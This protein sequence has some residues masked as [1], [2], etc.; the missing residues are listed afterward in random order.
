[1]NTA[2][3]IRNRAARRPCRLA[4]P[5]S[6]Q[7]ANSCQFG[8]KRNPDG[9]GFAAFGKVVKGMDVVK[10]F[11]PRPPKGNHSRRR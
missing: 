5:R 4:E 9:R 1:M 8:G 2:I 7:K 3:V 10:K 11:S 6:V